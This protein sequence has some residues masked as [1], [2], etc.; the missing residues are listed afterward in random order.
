MSSA[1]MW[2]DVLMAMSPSR[3]AAVVMISC[4]II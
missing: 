2:T 4:L 3:T 1:R